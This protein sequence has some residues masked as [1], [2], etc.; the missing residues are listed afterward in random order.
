MTFRIKRSHYV[1]KTELLENQVIKGIKTPRELKGSKEIS[2][3]K[4]IKQK[5]LLS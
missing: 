1:N 2:T 5:T 3:T 4:Q